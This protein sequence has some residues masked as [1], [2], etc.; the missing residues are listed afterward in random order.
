MRCNC[1]MMS[2][3]DTSLVKE[4]GADVDQADRDGAEREGGVAESNCR[5]RNWASLRLTVV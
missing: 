1:V 4:D 3:R 5:N 2:L